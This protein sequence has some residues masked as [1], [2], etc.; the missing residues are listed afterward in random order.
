MFMLMLCDYVIC[1][2]DV[3]LKTDEHRVDVF[4]FF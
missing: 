4:C 2:G 1:V 3:F